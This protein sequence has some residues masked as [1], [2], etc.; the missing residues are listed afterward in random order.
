MTKHIPI[1]AQIILGHF[2]DNSN[3]DFKLYI[4]IHRNEVEPFELLSLNS[5]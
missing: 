2:T 1:K 5:A 4:L 3:Q